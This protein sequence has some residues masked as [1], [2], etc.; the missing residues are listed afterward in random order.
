MDRMITEIIAKTGEEECRVD[1]DKLH[2]ALLLLPADKYI[3]LYH[4]MRSR[5]EGKVVFL[6]DNGKPQIMC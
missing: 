1:V 5:I 3:E 6:D 2:E 4:E